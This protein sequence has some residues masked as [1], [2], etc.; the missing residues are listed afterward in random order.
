MSTANARASYFTSEGDVPGPPGDA[1]REYKAERSDHDDR[2]PGVYRGPVESVPA[3]RERGLG[4][5]TRARF[6]LLHPGR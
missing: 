6:D 3:R 1:P 4:Q 5:R 2:E